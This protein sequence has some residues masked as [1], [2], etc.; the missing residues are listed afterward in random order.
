[1][2]EIGT[3]WRVL[4]G[5]A[6]A[7]F[8]AP[9]LIEAVA[10]GRAHRR[11]VGRD[12]GRRA[13]DRRSGAP[14]FARSRHGGVGGRARSRAVREPCR[15]A[16]A[17]RRVRVREPDRRE[18][19]LAALCSTTC[20]GPT[21][22]WWIRC[23]ATPRYGSGSRL[24]HARSGTASTSTWCGRHRQSSGRTSVR[25]SGRTGCVTPTPTATR[26]T[27]CRATR[28]GRRT[29]QP[30][31]TRCSVR[32]RATAPPRRRS[33]ARLA[34]AVAALAHQAGFPLLIDLRPGLVIIDSG[35]DQWEAD[36]HGLELDVADLAA[37][38]QT[39]ARELGGL[40]DPKLPRI[41]AALPRC[42]R[43]RRSP[44]VLG[45]RTRLHPGP[46]SRGH[47]HPRSEAAE[48]GAGVPGARRGRTRSAACSATACT[49][50]SLC[51]RNSGRRTSPLPSLPADGSSTS[52]RF[53]GTS[54]TPRATNS[55]SSS[56]HEPAVRSARTHSCM[57]TT[58]AMSKIAPR[59][60]HDGSARRCGGS[61]VTWRTTV[62]RS[63]RTSTRCSPCSPIPTPTRRG[64]SGTQR[65][66]PSMPIGH[67]R[68]ASSTTESACGRSR[69]PTAPSSRRSSRV[70]SCGSTCA[71]ASSGGRHV[72]VDR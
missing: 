9:S 53:A 38:I 6:T 65:C 63:R 34:A 39:A 54:P 72:P 55:R 43:R 50:S 30:T 29:R 45:R 49:S 36:A 24:T 51:R 58:V 69:S 8:D 19:V 48:P 12:R 31:G 68:A 4:D 10:V 5:V 64:W 35:K 28:S 23:G 40:A 56:T 57:T 15:A 42:R 70:S 11:S 16:A 44:S 20:P 61:P 26:S 22:V 3:D 47:R 67:G 21:A 71:P 2:T 33:N 1:M 14:C 32:W 25:R 62:V 59:S 17:E 37:H 66:G 46:A 41:R 52:R 60:R 13:G 7:W 18:S 27:W